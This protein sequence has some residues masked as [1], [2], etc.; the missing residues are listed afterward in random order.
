MEFTMDMANEKKPKDLFKEGETVV[1]IVSM[2]HMISKGGNSM[3]KCEIKQDVTGATDY[4][5]FIAE[6]KKR[7]LLK[8]LLDATGQY[9]KDSN[10]K[11]T[12]DTENVVG[13]KVLAE[14]YHEEQP[15]TDSTGKETTVKNNR[16]KIFKQSEYTQVPQQEIS[17]EDI[18]F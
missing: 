16:I 4:F 18:P 14:V 6:E 7:W 8:S 11:Y 13:C 9:K 15:W 2:E 1:T 3:F 17:D 10:N 5:Y 12:F